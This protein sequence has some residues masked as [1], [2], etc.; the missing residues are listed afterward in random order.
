M[1]VDVKITTQQG[2]EEPLSF[3][4]S[5]EFVYGTDSS[6]LLYNEVD[7]ELA[8]VVTQITTFSSKRILMERTGDWVS[9]MEFKLGEELACSYKIPY[10]EMQ[11][12][13]YTFA[14]SNCLNKCGGT[15]EF[16]YSIGSAPIAM[17]ANA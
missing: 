16:E 2:K 1:I 8:G 7:P 4:T 11:M 17:T 15:L 6:M 10:G 12:Y 14:I 9:R 5:G 13:S 3:K